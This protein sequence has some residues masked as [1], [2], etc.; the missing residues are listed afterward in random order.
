M[1]SHACGYSLWTQALKRDRDD[2]RRERDR[3]QQE[4]S[5]LATCLQ[6]SHLGSVAN[7]MSMAQAPGT[8]TPQQQLE[9]MNMGLSAQQL[10]Q[11]NSSNAAN[12]LAGVPHGLQVPVRRLAAS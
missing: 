5:K 11:L 10:A 4:V 8:Q 3:L 6:Y 1:L 7:A 9:H 12:L 2:M